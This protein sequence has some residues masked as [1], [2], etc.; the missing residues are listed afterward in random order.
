MSP[1]LALAFAT[2]L[3]AASRANRPSGIDAQEAV[4]LND[5]WGVLMGSIV[6]MALAVLVGASAILAIRT[7]IYPK[8]FGWA[9]ALIAIGMLSPYSYIFILPGFL[10]LFVVSIWLYTRTSSKVV[11]ASPGAALN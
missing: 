3:A 6:P 11:S 9:S 7:A 8:W 10:W 4:M 1:V 5:L 2:V